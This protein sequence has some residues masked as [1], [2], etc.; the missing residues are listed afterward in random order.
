MKK[1]RYW[2]VAAFLL[3]VLLFLL[4]SRRSPP[5]RLAVS[6]KPQPPPHLAEKPV[7]LPSGGILP[8]GYKVLP[9]SAPPIPYS[10][11]QDRLKYVSSFRPKNYLVVWKDDGKVSEDFA[12]I[13]SLTPEQCDLIYQAKV[14]A[15]QQV[16]K[17]DQAHLQL[18]VSPDGKKVSGTIS[19]YPEEGEQV[20]A[21]FLTKVSAAMGPETYA[22]FSQDYSEVFFDD[23]G[24]AGTLNKTFTLTSQAQGGYQ[25]NIQRRVANAGPDLAL[26]VNTTAA[27]IQDWN[28]LR[29]RGLYVDVPKPAPVQP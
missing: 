4:L 20:T 24:S 7:G 11:E 17:L 26:L 5:P 25:L 9:V 16:T 12:K 23:I 19:P 27:D 3:L 14:A 8:E 28:E 10:Y 6:A 18:S 1:Y 21:D 22:R 29:R 15:E 2:F 13:Y